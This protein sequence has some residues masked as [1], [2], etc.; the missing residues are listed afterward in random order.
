MLI[1]ELNLYAHGNR[2]IKLYKHHSK[3][4]QKRKSVSW[5]S[6]LTASIGGESSNLTLSGIRTRVTHH[7]QMRLQ[8]MSLIATVYE[9]SGYGARPELAPTIYQGGTTSNR[10]YSAAHCNLTP[11]LESSSRTACIRL[12]QRYGLRRVDEIILRA[13]GASD[14]DISRIKRGDLGNNKLDALV[15]SFWLGDSLFANS[16]IERRVMSICH[17]VPHE[18]NTEIDLRLE[19]TLRPMA[20]HAYGE[21]SEGQISAFE[22]VEK[23]AKEIRRKLEECIRHAQVRIKHLKKFRKFRKRSLHI[24]KLSNRKSFFGKK[25]ESNLLHSTRRWREASGQCL[26]DMEGAPPAR[27]DKNV[28]A[29]HPLLDLSDA[30]DRKVS[31]RK[32]MAFIRKCALSMSSTKMTKSIEKEIDS[33]IAQY[34]SFIISCKGQ[35]DGSQFTLKDYTAVFGKLDPVRGIRVPLG[36]KELATEALWG[37]QA[38]YLLD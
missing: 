25:M 19:N 27:L 38:F 35:L 8:V 32:K 12:I 6:N 23:V 21:V 7:A 24:V 28:N 9:V 2:G 31:R 26:E 4:K 15:N 36:P 14:D 30:L 37:L 34:R 17:Q 22:A 3:K 10:G 13:K 29:Y 16:W 33:N 11:H 18:V 20:V 5:G 1:Q